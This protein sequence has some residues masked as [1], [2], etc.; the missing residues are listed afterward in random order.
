ML[1]A[2]IRCL[3]LVV[4]SS[5]DHNCLRVL[6]QELIRRMMFELEQLVS[7]SNDSNDSSGLRKLVLQVQV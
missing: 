3:E 4:N 7:D 2:S 5:V 6:T 1:V